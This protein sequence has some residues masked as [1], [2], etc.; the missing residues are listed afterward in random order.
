[1]SVTLMEIKRYL[2]SAGYWEENERR[3]VTTPAQEMIPTAE[4]FEIPGMSFFHPVVLAPGAKEAYSSRRQT[5]GGT[6]PQILIT[7]L[8]VVSGFLGMSI[9][10]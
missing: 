6:S 7:L 4:P 2:A 8:V 1:M 3:T 9:L 5:A 10:T